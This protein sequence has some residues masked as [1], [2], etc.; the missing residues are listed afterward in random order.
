MPLRY[1]LLLAAAVLAA[2]IVA[3]VIA[4][5]RYLTT[6]AAE[7]IDGQ[8]TD[9]LLALIPFLVFFYPHEF[10]WNFLVF[11]AL[12]GL[13]CGIIFLLNSCGKVEHSLEMQKV[14]GLGTPMLVGLGYL[15]FVH[16][17]PLFSR[18]P[19]EFIQQTGAVET[20]WFWWVYG[21]IWCLGLLLSRLRGGVFLSG[22]TLILAA[23]VSPLFSGHY[24]SALALGCVLFGLSLPLINRDP[25]PQVRGVNVLMLLMLALFVI[26]VSVLVY[27]VFF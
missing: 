7:G 10:W 16:D 12:W 15:L 25:A 19:A 24:W 14:M 9:A 11:M 22:L 23:A 5:R 6:G 18:A 1:T 4:Y 17:G 8:Q 26:F 21:L 20:G 2:A 27:S 13:G 3:D